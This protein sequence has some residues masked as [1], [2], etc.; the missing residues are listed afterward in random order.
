MAMT[1][2]QIQ[3]VVA[4]QSG[5]AKSFELLYATFY[6]KVYGFS[7]MILR[8]ET[9]AEDVLQ[10]AFITAWNR[11]GT[12]QNPAAF[13]VWIQIIAKN[14]CNMQLRRKNIAILLDAEQ[15]IQNFDIE[16]DE[17]PLPAIYAERADLKERLG[18]I[19]DGLSDTQ[20]QT[21]VLY[22][23][24]ELSVDEIAAVMECS[25]G[26]VK[27]RLFLARK[28]IRAEIEEE[29]RKSGEK[30]YG[31]VGLLTL[32]FGRFVQSHMESLSIGQS[33][34]R[35]SFFAIKN[36]IAS[37]GRS[38]ASG[39]GGDST[40]QTATPPAEAP[41]MNT[42]AVDAKKKLSLTT[43][44]AAAI[45]VVA[46][47]GAVA[48]IALLLA[49]GRI[50]LKPSA[51]SPAPAISDAADES[52][53][54]ADAGPTS[55]P[56][57][58]VSPT[59]IDPSDSSDESPAP[60]EL[61]QTATP[62]EPS[63]DTVYDYNDLSTAVADIPREEAL[64]E[65]YILLEGYWITNDD[66]FFGFVYIDGVPGIE[67][68]LFQTEFGAAGK[69]TG[70]HATGAYEAELTV[71]FPAVA[72]DMMSS[73]RPESTQTVHIDIGGLYEPGSTIKVKVED[74]GNGGWYT[75]QY[76]GA[77]VQEAFQSKQSG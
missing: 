8:N 44:I 2:Q 5:D 36:S 30:F 1:D 61:L 33:A 12:L 37:P 25:P 50:T 69:I 64:D 40:V 56:D 60:S 52:P 75:Y 51:G 38:S 19:I 53:A 39:L 34:A 58:N 55:A 23:F 47:L 65:M 18:R 73:G 7:R 48:V 17:E 9:E 15:D 10:E 26:T 41:N 45:S 59:E 14:L 54:P 20:R 43:K 22:Y 62:G 67:Y 72:E 21:I 71:F 29:E 11:L 70:G 3:L 13:S 49:S 76:G 27:S 35:N 6:E 66:P 16:E 32:P 68:G 57:G 28:T 63:G 46:V 42:G 31:I 4:A 77:S 24:N 74:L